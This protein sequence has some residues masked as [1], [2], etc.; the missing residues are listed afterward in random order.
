MLVV[1]TLGFA[2]QLLGCSPGTRGPHNFPLSSLLSRVWA[3]TGVSQSPGCSLQVCKPWTCP[4]SR[5]K[6]E[7]SQWHRHQWLNGWGKL[8]CLTQGPRVSPHSVWQTLGRTW[9]VGHGGHLCF[10][11]EGEYWPQIGSLVTR[12]TG[13]RDTHAPH[14]PFG[15]LEVDMFWG[16]D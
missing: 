6:K 4:A 7:P 11:L 9:Q 12:E 1:A 15:K 5:L 10:R 3:F 14:H 8:T 13:S 2:P 16:K